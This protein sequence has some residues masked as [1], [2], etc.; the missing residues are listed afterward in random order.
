VSRRLISR[1]D[2]EL[3]LVGSRTIAQQ[4]TAKKISRHADL[5]L[6]RRTTSQIVLKMRRHRITNGKILGASALLAAL[7]LAPVVNAGSTESNP[8]GSADA[9]DDQKND[10]SPQK[11]SLHFQN[12]DIIQGVTN[13]SSPYVGANS[14]TP[15]QSRE[16]VTATFFFACRLWQGSTLVVNPEYAQGQ[17]LNLTHGVAGFPNGEATKAGS[18]PGKVDIA[19]I[20]L[21]QVIGFGGEQE[22]VADAKNQLVG[23]RDISRLTIS[24]GKCAADD[25]F[26]DNT[27]THDPRNQ[28]L[29]WSIWE[30]AAWD[31][32]ADAKGYTAG[33]VVEL[34]QKMWALRYGA[35]LMPRVANGISLQTNLARAL[36]EVVEYEQRYSIPGDHIGKVRLLAYVNHANMG[37]YQ[38]AI[39]EFR[40]N[41]TAPANITLSRASRLKYGGAI[42]VEQEL[43]QDLGI[44]L[45]LSLNNGATESWAFTEVDR[46]AALGVAIKGIRWG[47]SKDTVGLCGVVNGLSSVHAQ[48]LADGGL[49]ILLGDGRLRY[50]PEQ[51]IE[52]YYDAKLPLKYANIMLGY[53]FIRNPGYNSQRGPANVLSARFHVE[54]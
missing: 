21:S 41:P 14:L 27:F 13:F 46:S 51:I 12:T 24:F 32:P 23:K 15:S 2:G 40:A 10:A 47:R 31:Y 53:Q 9:T 25:F 19:R 54:F 48:Y 11:W 39:D 16:T 35:F 18:L 50:G 36:G 5:R 29:N 17:G 52:T 43:T 34:N 37:S 26:D 3:S 1:Y 38:D 33:A 8:S 7:S 4:F 28:F 44:F 30:S 49:G 6:S 45:R 22:D 42:N 20:Y